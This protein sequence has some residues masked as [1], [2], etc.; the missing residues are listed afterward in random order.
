MPLAAH[1]A[2]YAL[3]CM[4]IPS[5]QAQALTLVK[6]RVSCLKTQR[7]RAGLVW[8]RE[9]TLNRCGIGIAARKIATLAAIRS[10]EHTSE[11]QSLTNLVCRLLLEKK[12][13]TLNHNDTT[14]HTDRHI[15]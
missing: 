1:R 2:L 8:T 5:G 13:K 15:P 14:I 6:D 7:H 11:L 12:K 3:L 10:E 9:S 4:R